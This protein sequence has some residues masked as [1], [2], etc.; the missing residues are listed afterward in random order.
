MNTILAA[1]EF[2]GM[3]NHTPTRRQMLRTMGMALAIPALRAS[4]GSQAGSGALKFRLTETAGLRRFAYPVQTL[5]SNV[6]TA[7]HFRL[8]RGERPI[9][10]QFRQ[11]T[12]SDGRPGIALDFYA[13][14]GP[15]ET[16]SYAIQYG[17]T[18]QRGPEPAQGMHVAHADG[19]F[20]VANGSILKFDVPET[21]LGF[22]QGVV[23]GRDSFLR[24]DSA[25][26]WL[27]TRDGSRE[28]LGDTVRGR[29]PLRATVAR[30]GPI[31]VALRFASS[32]PQSAG[33]AVPSVC[34]LTFPQTKSWVETNWTVSDPEGQV[35]A[36]GLDLNLAV[37]GP[38]T[39]VD[40]GASSTVYGQLQKQER[41]TLRA[42]SLPGQP[43]QALWE[44]RKGPP[45]AMPLLAVPPRVN[46]ARAEGWAHIMDPTRCTAVA[47]F[48]FGRSTLDRIEISAHGELRLV[49]EFAAGDGAP[50]AGPKSL[51]FWLHFVG[52]PVQVGAATSPQAMLAPLEVEWE[53]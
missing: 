29:A 11:V 34:T 27:R 15:L 31:A 47:V 45:E 37:A 38:A 24:G 48:G 4:E 13:S 17:D 50:P 12:R 33:R 43:S 6:R 9:A 16:E 41:M 22:L 14:P 49:R 5:I 2:L 19:R 35:T 52:M 28:R 30:E 42:G 21:L 18:V 26:L 53:A 10:A 25:G 23:N 36:L 7:T 46:P 39:L 8:L 44:V 40:L 20:Q 3:R 32:A 51:R 1:G